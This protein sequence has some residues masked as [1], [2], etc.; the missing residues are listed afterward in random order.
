MKIFFHFAV[1]GF[2]NTY[3]IGGDHGGDAILIDPG[4]MDIE[5]LKLIEDNDYYVRHILFTHRHNS[6]THGAKTL[7]KIY[8]ADIYANSPYILDLPVKIIQ[9]GHRFTLCGIDIEAVLV[10]GHSADSLVY[11][12]DHAMFTG[13][14]LMAGRIGST[15]SALSKSLLQ[16]SIKEKIMPKVDSMLIFPGHG[17]PTTLDIER[18]I[19]LDLIPGAAQEHLNPKIL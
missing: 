3:L 10:P 16:R 19:N 12:I 14:V 9:D 6:H 1:I 15:D 5:L 13:D 11:I 4:Y 2:S 18:Q 8:D 17:T 7:L